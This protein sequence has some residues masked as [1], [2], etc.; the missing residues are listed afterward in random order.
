MPTFKKCP[1][2]KTLGG[3]RQIRREKLVCQ[4]ALPCRTCR[5]CPAC[6]PDIKKRGDKKCKN[7]IN[8]LINRKY[9]GY[10]RY[11]CLTKES[12]I[13]PVLINQPWDC[14]DFDDGKETKEEK[15]I[16]KTAE[17]VQVRA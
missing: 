4:N 16:P 11:Y 2:Y 14:E 12:F 15:E 10:L 17:G 9:K 1:H 13:E 7:C 8:L 3:K 6:P 5:R